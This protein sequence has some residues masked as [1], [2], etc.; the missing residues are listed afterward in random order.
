M[1]D[2]YDAKRDMLHKL[3][4]SMLKEDGIGNLLDSLKG[5]K[6]HKVAVMSDSPE[7]LQHGLDKASQILKAK[8]G[9]GMLGDEEENDDSIPSE[10]DE[11][12]SPEDLKSKILAL[13]LKLNR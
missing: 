3:K 6:V 8:E 12:E 1:K 2:K 11:N 7:G 4:K 13:K 9:D 5:K 10:D